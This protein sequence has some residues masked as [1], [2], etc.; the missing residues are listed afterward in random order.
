MMMSGFG[1]IAAAVEAVK[2]GAEDYIT[3]PFERTTVL[4]KIQSIWELQSLR[5]KV[6]ELESTHRPILFGGVRSYRRADRVQETGQ[7]ADDIPMF[8]LVR[9]EKYAIEQALRLSGNNKSRARKILG[10]SRQ[11]LYHKMRQYGIPLKGTLSTVPKS[12]IIISRGS[13]P[14]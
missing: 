4:K 11:S 2:R 1:T 5:E 12:D 8:P 10:I 6:A 13:A 9:L 14:C 3:K 7:Q